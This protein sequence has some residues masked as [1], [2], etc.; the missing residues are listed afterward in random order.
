M[1]MLP[2]QS[3]F[4]QRYYNHQMHVLWQNKQECAFIENTLGTEFSENY[5]S[6]THF[7]FMKDAQ[8]PI[9]EGKNSFKSAS[10]CVT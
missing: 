5:I 3:C 2:V 8:G 4:C 9:N 7:W 1:A 10:N 6:K